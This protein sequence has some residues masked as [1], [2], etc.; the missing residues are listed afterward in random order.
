LA[1]GAV[2]VYIAAWIFAIYAVREIIVRRR[3]VDRSRAVTVAFLGLTVLYVTVVSNA[4]DIG[5]NNRFRFETDAVMWVLFVVL[6]T[7]LAGIA[8]ARWRAGSPRDRISNV[9]D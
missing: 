2:L 4:I 8:A 5:E 6:L 9:P 3:N 1:W 7:R